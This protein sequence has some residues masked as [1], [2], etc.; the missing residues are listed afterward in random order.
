MQLDTRRQHAA[1]LGQLLLDILADRDKVAAHRLAYADGDGWHAVEPGQ[2]ALVFEAIL[3]RRHVAK[4]DWLIVALH[5]EQL[6]E[7]LEG[8]R[9]AHRPQIELDQVALDVA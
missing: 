4:V 6:A 8:I 5:D 9:L 3:D 1:K 2:A 7:L